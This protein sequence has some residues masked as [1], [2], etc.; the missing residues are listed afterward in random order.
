[1]NEEQNKRAL[2]AL[3]KIEVTLEEI[4]DLFPLI[5]AGQVK[6]KVANPKYTEP[7]KI[8]KRVN[9]GIIKNFDE[10]NAERKLKSLLEFLG[11]TLTRR[12]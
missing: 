12:N 8:L 10:S 1:M 11:V 7:L 9:N 6:I 2:D 3:R 4:K 5:P